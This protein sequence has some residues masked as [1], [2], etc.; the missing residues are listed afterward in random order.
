METEQ[1]R[2]IFLA[3]LFVADEPA[4]VDD[5]Y[6][7]LPSMEPAD[8]RRELLEFIDAYNGRREVFQIVE[9]ARGYQLRTRP[10]FAVWIKA[11]KR[12][13]KRV[14][15]SRQALEVLAIIAYRQPVTTPEVERIRGAGSAGVIKSLLEK[16][17]IRVL[18]R[19]DVPGKPIL[20]G[21]S[22]L[23]L[24]QFGLKD[25]AS[26]PT[27][28]ELK[29]IFHET[30]ESDAEYGTGSGSTSPPESDSEAAAE[31]TAD[32]AV[33]SEADPAADPA[34]EPA[35]DDESE[36]TESGGESSGCGEC[37]SVK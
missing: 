22:R 8:V 21:T 19:Q 11:F 23:F 10:E 35:A 28:T 29:E 24:E 16:G 18:G 17:F 5:I 32:S 33:A 20:Y 1:L 2:R 26:L 15:L 9:V 27:L 12:E 37:G 13:I 34:T 31:S 36:G 25:L 3:L 4:A 7:A 14:R 30:E 6:R